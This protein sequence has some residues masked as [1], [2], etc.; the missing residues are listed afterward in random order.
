[1]PGKSRPVAALDQTISR[2]DEAVYRAKF[3]GRNKVFIA[4]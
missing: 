2:A 3:A 4:E 1:M